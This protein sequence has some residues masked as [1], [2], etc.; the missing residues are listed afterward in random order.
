[1]TEINLDELRLKDVADMTA[2]D[3]AFLVEHK[4]DLTEEEV[5]AFSTFINPAEEGEEGEEGEDETEEEKAQ[6]EA[7]EAAAAAGAPKPPVFKTVEESE[8]WLA[9]KKKDWEADNAKAAEEAID[10]KAAEA[11][12]AANADKPIEFFQPGYKPKDYNA[13]A[14][15]LFK[16][17]VTNLGKNPTLVSD[18][19]EALGQMTAAERQTIDKINVEFDQEL[20]QM[21]AEGLVPD[22]T[23]DEGKKMDKI[24]TNIGARMGLGSMREAF[25]AYKDLG[26]AM[27]VTTVKTKADMTSQKQKASMVGRGGGGTA[28]PPKKNYQKDVHKKSMDDIMAE[29]KQELEG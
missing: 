14:N 23:T 19:R 3:K 13:F 16:V 20:K 24:L 18:I 10:A 12:A 17:I 8:K 1:M 6:R 15:D 5:A 28:T 2:E 25:A 4:A 11:A 22:P 21:A 7:D 29:A 9:D 27:G 26:S